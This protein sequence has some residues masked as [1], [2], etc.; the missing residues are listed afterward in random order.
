[1]KPHAVQK[2]EVGGAT[3]PRA[4]GTGAGHTLL[5]WVLS[6]ALVVT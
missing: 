5:L 3:D 1:M 4:R 6:D 2:V